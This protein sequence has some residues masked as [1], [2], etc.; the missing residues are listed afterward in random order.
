MRGVTEAQVRRTREA[1]AAKD[2]VERA[3]KEAD[4]WEFHTELRLDGRL[5]LIEGRMFRVR[6]ERGWF[7]FRNA[8]T[9]PPTWTRP[10]NWGP[11]DPECRTGI[12]CYGP[13]TK[14]GSPVGKGNPPF[15][16]FW[17]ERVSRVARGTQAARD[18]VAA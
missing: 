16:A 12:E 17:S 8:Y 2:A 3:A 15:R 7:K 5:P 13:Y 18:Q 6:G 4:G 9:L 10:R 14:D 11:V 1:N